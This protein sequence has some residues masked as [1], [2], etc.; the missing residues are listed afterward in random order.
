MV[1]AGDA[2][3]QPAQQRVVRVAAAIFADHLRA[4]QALERH[5]R[6]QARLDGGAFA[7]EEVDQ[8]LRARPLAG[9][10]RFIVEHQL[11][12]PALRQQRR[13]VGGAQD[14]V[15][16]IHGAQAFEQPAALFV[17]GGG[18]RIGEV[19]QACRRIARRGP[20]YRI[21]MDHPAAA[22]S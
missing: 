13:K 22:Q 16:F 6:R 1:D 8:A 3:L 17:D 18:H 5:G 14:E 10:R 12:E 20:P 19:R 2:E 11:D 15:A 7:A 21:D 9:R 4:A